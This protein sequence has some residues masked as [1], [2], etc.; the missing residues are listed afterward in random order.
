MTDRDPDFA[1]RKQL[2]RDA[3]EYFA[4]DISEQQVMAYVRD[5]LLYS[6]DALA[7]AMCDYRV[8]PIPPGRYRRPPLPIDLI[9]R[10]Q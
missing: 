4:Y 10:M 8:S 6:C 9:V 2:W 7:Q 5:T 1:T 3:Y